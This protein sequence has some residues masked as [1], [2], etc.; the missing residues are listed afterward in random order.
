MHNHAVAYSNSQ[1]GSW[2]DLQSTLIK[3]KAEAGMDNI[4]RQTQEKC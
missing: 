4:T 2:S 1:A 3:I